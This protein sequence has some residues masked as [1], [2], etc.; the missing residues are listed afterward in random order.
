MLKKSL[1]VSFSLFLSATMV[2]GEAL[3]SQNPEILTQ[4]SQMAAHSENLFSSQSFEVVLSLEREILSSDSSSQT[5]PLPSEMYWCQ[6]NTGKKYLLD[7]KETVTVAVPGAPNRR[8][9]IHEKYLSDGTSLT[10]WQDRNKSLGFYP[11][12]NPGRSD[13]KFRSLISEIKAALSSWV[14]DN[15]YQPEA[16]DKQDSSSKFQVDIQAAGCPDPARSGCL[17]VTRKLNKNHGLSPHRAEF[18]VD[19]NLGYSVVS[20]TFFDKD[21]KVA[22]KVTCS[23]FKPS[24]MHPT[25]YFAQKVVRDLYEGDSV[26]RRTTYT[27][28]Q[29]EIG[30]E[31]DQKTFD[32]DVLIS[33]LDP[34]SIVDFREN[35]PH[36]IRKPSE[37]SQ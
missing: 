34:A 21:G 29:L 31:F 35:P 9:V 36:V 22:Q 28:S 7:L 32:P 18:L 11:G 20:S 1:G 19:P 23:D 17:V 10:I 30:K 26:A 5:A 33:S 24:D 37:E 13:R 14:V 4:L 6:T 27:I 12:G 2:N 3:S 25:G 16:W 15:E 8:G